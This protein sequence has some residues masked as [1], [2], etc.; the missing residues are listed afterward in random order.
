MVTGTRHLLELNHKNIIG[1]FKIDY[2][3]GSGR[4]SGYIQ[5][6]TEF[7]VFYDPSR[8]ICYHTE[9]R[10]TKPAALLNQMIDLV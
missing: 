9:D 5:A 1:I 2:N 6:L 7:G 3:Q 10:K 4:H 8:V